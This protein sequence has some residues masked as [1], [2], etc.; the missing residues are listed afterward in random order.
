MKKIA[1]VLFLTICFLPC[2]YGQKTRLG[3][4]PPKA[5]L[6]VDYPI[7]LHVTG[8]HIRSHC[9]RGLNEVSCKDLLYVDAVQD[10]MKI[11]LVGD[12]NSGLLLVD[13]LPGDYRARMTAKSPIAF[14]PVL[15][16]GYEL[17]LSDNSV[18]RGD[19]SGYSE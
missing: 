5:K 7:Q 13:L 8:V 9:E 14:P 17:L 18:W 2:T 10:K 16:Q 11:E 19:I 15:G 3:Q 6:G 12:V 4:A 1:A